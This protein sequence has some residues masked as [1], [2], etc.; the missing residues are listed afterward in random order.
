ML[1]NIIKARNIATSEESNTQID[2][3]VDQFQAEL[4]CENFHESAN[5]ESELAKNGLTKNDLS[6]QKSAI[7]SKLNSK[8]SE[9]ADKV[10]EFKDNPKYTARATLR[11]WCGYALTKSLLGPA[12]AMTDTESFKKTCA[13][14]NITTQ[15]AQLCAL[16]NPTGKFKNEPTTMSVL[17][18]EEG[19]YRVVFIKY[20]EN[21]LKTLFSTQNDLF[22]SKNDL[23]MTFLDPKLTSVKNKT[24]YENHPAH[25]TR[26]HRS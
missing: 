1:E 24:F 20:H 26:D 2:S 19:K 14:K 18:N 8:K 11:G 23:K 16:G 25:R 21:E 12:C 7:T 15:V 22:W 5:L 4:F 6:D 10:K 9:I 17:E 3:F 13:S